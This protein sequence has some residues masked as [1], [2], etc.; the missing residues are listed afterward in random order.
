MDAKKLLI[1]LALLCL[2]APVLADAELE[3]RLWLTEL[4]GTLQVTEGSLGTV[5]DIGNDLGVEDDEGLEVRLTWRMPGPLVVRFGYVPLSFSGSASLDRDIE[6]GGV[7]FPVQFDL[8]TEL[9]LDYAR[10]GVGWLFRVN[11]DFRIG[12]MIELK[13][14]R[15]EASLRGSVLGIP[16]AAAT[17]SEETGF[18]SIGIAFDGK[19]LP[20]LHIVGEAGYSPGLDFGDMIEA[21][22]GI[23]FSPTEIFSVFGG[24]RLITLDLE[25][26]DDRLDFDLSGP[27]FGASLTF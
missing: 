19:P 27:Y 20:T 7:T 21:E 6:F 16:L 11:E 8:G 9:E 1:T 17:E 2:P 4:D 23:K 24:Y 18:G 3:V 5:L 13:A 14:I 25:H 22:L 15:A 10:A 12:P 26:D